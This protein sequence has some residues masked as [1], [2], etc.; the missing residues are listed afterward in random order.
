MDAIFADMP[1]W[2]IVTA[3]GITLFAGFVKGAV[4]FAFPMIVLSGLGSFLAPETAL[5]ILILPTVV[6]NVFQAFRQGLGAAFAVTRHYWLFLS[7]MVVFLVFSAQLVTIIPAAV[8]LVV[9]GIPMILFAILQ[10]SRWTLTLRPETRTRD[11][12]L[13]GGFAG[14]IGGMSGSWGPPTVLY[15]TAIGAEK[16]ETMRAQGVIYGIGAVALLFAHIQS[17]V[18]NAVTWQ[19]SAAALVPAL[20]GMWLGLKVHDRMPQKTFRRAMLVVLLFAGLNLV[21]RGLML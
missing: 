8:M 1:L 21:R 18:L 20:A 10:L 19:L 17:G 11:E 13:I 9:V 6:T 15:L 3:V 2:L 4:G 7:I 5:A 12:L 14:F 16:S